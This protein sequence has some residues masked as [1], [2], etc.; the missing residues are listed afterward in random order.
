MQLPRTALAENMA[1]ETWVFCRLSHAG[2]WFKGSQFTPSDRWRALPSHLSTILARKRFHRSTK[3]S[4]RA[5]VSSRLFHNLLGL[6]L[7]RTRLAL[8]RATG[9]R[10]PLRPIGSIS[11]SF[12]I[13]FQ[14]KFYRNSRASAMQYRTTVTGGSS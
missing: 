11:V 2:A 7:N 5:L 4:C 6:E 12:C 3:N 8:H 1:R 14:I 13:S 9:Q 10:W